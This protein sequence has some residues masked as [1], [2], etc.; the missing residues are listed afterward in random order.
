VWAALAAL[1]RDGVADLVGRT[2]QL[3]RRFA[4][5]MR[6][7]GIG[8]LN[9]VVL[10]QVV[11]EFGSPARTEAVIAAVQAGGTCWCGPTTWQGR[12]AMRISVSGWNTTAGDIERSI[13]AVVAASGLLRSGRGWRLRRHR[14]FVTS[15]CS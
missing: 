12:T 13:A 8:V 7:A 1:G 5:G 3:A 6:E 9:D 10:N 4:A 14:L 15:A 2:C 11:V